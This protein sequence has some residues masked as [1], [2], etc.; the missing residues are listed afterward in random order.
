[1]EV[2]YPLKTQSNNKNFDK[3]LR[4]KLDEINSNADISQQ[5]K[6]DDIDDSNSTGKNRS[7]RVRDDPV[8]DHLESYSNKNIDIKPITPVS[9]L[10]LSSPKEADTKQLDTFSIR[11]RLYSDKISL[12]A[13][14]DSEESSRN[15]NDLNDATKE[16]ER[17]PSSILRK[18]SIIPIQEVSRGLSGKLIN[19]DNEI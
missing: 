13:R 14:V 1:M 15:K 3:L 6:T 12:N 5:N 7:F 18:P 9:V 11:S 16:R 4:Q 8:G 17:T 2:E 19:S 10:K